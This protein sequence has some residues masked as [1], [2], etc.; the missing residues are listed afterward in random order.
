VLSKNIILRIDR[1]IPRVLFLCVINSGYLT[2]DE[3]YV[4][5]LSALAFSYNEAEMFVNGDYAIDR[6]NKFKLPNIT[7]G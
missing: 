5:A 1:D 4:T 3:I 7:W 2:I 6:D